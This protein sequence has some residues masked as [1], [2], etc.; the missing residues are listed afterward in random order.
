M[1][2]Y[3]PEFLQHQLPLLFIA[4]LQ[5]PPS[6]NQS[7]DDTNNKTGDGARS[8]AGSSATDGFRSRSGSLALSGQQA[9]RG[10]LSADS[11]LR[12]YASGIDEVAGG[13]GSASAPVEEPVDPNTPQ[14]GVSTSDGTA[15]TTI[16][17]SA[18]EN[19]TVDPFIK[20]QHSLYEKLRSVSGKGRVWK[21]KG[22]V[23]KIGLVDK[24]SSDRIFALGKQPAAVFHLR[25][26]FLYFFLHLLMIGLPIPSP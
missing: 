25:L 4:G 10:R 20:L 15:T 18:V 13:A 8:R 22:E 21:R 11:I 19:S 6:S 1:N 9:G 3:P 16:E 17:S 12:G 26:M 23:Y 7:V 2:S 24:V 5:A 14:A